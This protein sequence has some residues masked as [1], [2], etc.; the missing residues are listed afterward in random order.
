MFYV[1]HGEKKVWNNAGGYL[2]IGGF[3]VGP[4]VEV[5]DV[6]VPDPLSIVKYVFT[7]HAKGLVV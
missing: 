6:V 5:V 1:L 4:S 7:I 2:L 3:G